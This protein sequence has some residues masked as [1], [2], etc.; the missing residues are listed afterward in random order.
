M[1]SRRVGAKGRD[2]AEA[3]G[4]RVQVQ[5]G[6]PGLEACQNH[7]WQKG[8]SGVQAEDLISAGFRA[9]VQ[10]LGGGRG[11]GGRS[12]RQP[13]G[14]RGRGVL[15]GFEPGTRCGGGSWG[16]GASFATGQGGPE[17]LYIYIYIYVY[18]YICIY[19]YI[20]L[21]NLL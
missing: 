14:A 21:Y 6:G 2:S 9:E 10:G 16:Q 5:V 12:R 7:G 11:V 17:R 20:P 8:F 19:I 18:L 3:G 4:S 1:K 15:R 13:G